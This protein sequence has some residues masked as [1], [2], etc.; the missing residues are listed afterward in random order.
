MKNKL[1]YLLIVLVFINCSKNNDAE[2]K[3][4]KLNSF[5]DFNFL[6]QIDDE[7]Y[8]IVESYEYNGSKILQDDSLLIYHKENVNDKIVF[9]TIKISK[10]KMDTLYSKITQELKPSYQN[11]KATEVIPRP[12]SGDDE[13]RRC[14]IE[15]DLI[16][17]G[18][19]KYVLTKTNYK[20]FMGNLNIKP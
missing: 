2:K 8:G 1:I 13:W 7:R 18:G 9:D 5:Y 15:L 11:N 12:P 4:T 16:F 10:K 19:N 14:K 3:H 17:R 6:I 20:S